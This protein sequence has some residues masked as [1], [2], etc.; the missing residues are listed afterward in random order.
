MPAFAMRTL[1]SQPDHARFLYV[2]R[3][4]LPTNG[5]MILPESTSITCH[6]SW[7]FNRLRTKQFIRVSCGVTT[8]SKN[9]AD[10]RLKFTGEESRQRG[11]IFDEIKD[12][13]REHEKREIH[14]S[15]PDN[16][17]ETRPQSSITI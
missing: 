12:F 11:S 6:L 17:A 8:R 15:D 5:A 7:F 3:R 16:I 9:G 4:A 14:S 2:S 1:P 13:I 10:A